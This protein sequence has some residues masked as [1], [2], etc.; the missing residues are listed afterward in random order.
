MGKQIQERPQVLNPKHPRKWPWI[1]VGVLLVIVAAVMWLI[2]AIL[3]SGQFTRWVQAKINASTGGQANIGDLSVGWFRGVRVDNFRFRGPNGWASVD[4]DRITTQ[5]SYGRL[6]SGSL[7]LQRTEID[8]PHITV[9]LR[10]QPPSTASAKTSSSPAEMP[11]LSRIGDLVVRDGTVQL[12]STTGQTVKV[13]DLNSELNVRPPGRE[14]RF[15]VDMTVAQDK[16]PAEVRASGR[17][18]PSPK[19]GWSLRGTSGQFTV[20]VNDLNMA[21]VAPLLDLAG[22]KVQAKGQLTA[23]I[24]SDLQN[25]QI[26]NL[27]ATIQGRNIDVTGPALKGDHP[28]T[29]R[30]DVQVNVPKIA[31]T[32]DVKQLHVQ[33]DWAN[34]SAAGEFPKTVRSLAQLTE[35][36]AAFNVT[37]NLDINLAAVLSQMSNTLGVQK[38]MQ[39]TG[40]RA[41]GNISTANQAGRPTLVAKV[42]VADLAG[43]VNGKKLSLPQ[44][45]QAAAQLSNGPQGAQLDDLSVSSPF[46]KLNASGN[47]KQIKYN[48]QVDLQALQ[49]DLGPFINLGQY[50]IGGQVESSGQVSM[51][52]NTTNLV[53]SLSARQFVL[54]RPDGNSVSTPQATANFAL[55][56]N[57]K[58]QVL[59]VETLNADTGF[60]TINVN[61]GTIPLAQNSPTPLNL[62]VAVDKLDLSKIKPYAAFFASFPKDLT[63]AGIAQSRVNVTQ[64]KGVYHISSSATKIQNLQVASAKTEPFKQDY[65]TAMFDVLIDSTLSTNIKSLQVDS[66]QF[67]IHKGEFVRT[68]EGNNTKFQGVLEGQVDLAAVGQVASKFVPGGGLEISGQRPISANFASTYPTKDPNAMLANLNGKATLGFDQA[69]YLG[70]DVGTTDLSVQVTNGLMQIGPFS[71]PVNNGQVSFAGRADLRKKPMALTIP[72]SLH[73]VQNV[74]IT[75]GTAD[76]LFKYVNPI[77]ADTA[78]ASGIVNFDLQQM[79][80]P[81]TSKDMIQDMQLTGTLRMDQVQLG[82]SGILNQILSVRGES[83]RGQ[84]LTVHPT[85]LVMQNGVVRYDDMQIDVGDNPVNF[86]GSIGPKGS[87]NMTV[88]LPYTVEGRTARVGQESQAGERII[89]PLTGTVDKPKLDL[90]KLMQSQIKEQAIKALEDLLKRK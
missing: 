86:R 68:T 1:L 47:P 64:D 66:P 17:A 52:D 80:I 18:T 44:P 49:S 87:L 74:Q 2:P 75:P 14:S 67:K 8:Q 13:A 57:Q 63:L 56:L 40:G 58:Q 11:D 23:H 73:L 27:D 81:L 20:E 36:G 25:G 29:S 72:T 45:I 54:T 78:S 53:G 3:S 88:V 59:A 10:E 37:G 76:K 50:R 30:L 48:G 34:V 28:Q 21:S 22:I 39:I 79:S 7:A 42:Q 12:T 60:G 84:Q 24:T 51:G 62:Q 19:T 90:Q 43:V 46:A 65:V 41:T 26:E 77:F 82:A 35:S 31:D 38:G 32:I 9:D 69:K 71:S 4:V 6:L 15:S 89:V 61:K 5:P 83:M 33:T 55:G 85:N 70:F 16:S